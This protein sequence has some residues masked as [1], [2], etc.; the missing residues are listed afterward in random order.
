[1]KIVT[2]AILKNEYY[3]QLMVPLILATLQT[4]SFFI[5]LNIYI[6]HNPMDH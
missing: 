4:R 1:M 5:N 2:Q 6:Y 3:S